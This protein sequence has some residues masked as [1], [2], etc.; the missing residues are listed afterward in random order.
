M[1]NGLDAYLRVDLLDSV[2]VEGVD[3]EAYFD[4]EVQ[5]VLEEDLVLLACLVGDDDV[6]LLGVAVQLAS[7]TPTNG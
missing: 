3:Q 2:V 4:L 6:L 7:G 1:K 5:D